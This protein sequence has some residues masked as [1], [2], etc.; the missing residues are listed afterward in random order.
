MRLLRLLAVVGAGLALSPAARAQRNWPSFDVIQQTPVPVGLV[1]FQAQD[2]VFARREPT[3]IMPVYAWQVREQFREKYGRDPVTDLEIASAIVDWVSTKLRHPFFYPDDP[4]QPRFYQNLAGDPA[5]ATMVLDPVRILDFTMAFDPDDP[6]TWPSPLCSYQN[7]AAAGLLNYFG[8]HA[9]LVDVDG[10]TS[11][12]YFSF[13]EHRWIWMDAT[14]NEHFITV[15]PGGAEVP[16]GVKELH[17]LAIAGQSSTALPVKHGYPSARW[18]DYTY[19][20]ARPDG[21]LRYAPTTYMRN[22]DGGGAALRRYHTVAYVPPLPPGLDPLP[23]DGGWLYWPRVFDGALL[24]YP[25]DGIALDASPTWDPVSYIMVVR[26]YLPF[27]TAFELFDASSQ[28]WVTRQ[29]IAVPT[30]DSTT[31]EP[32]R[33][34]WGSGLVRARARDGRGNVTQE[35][36]VQFY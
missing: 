17:A 12:E 25:V 5:Y 23:E 4:Y 30:S 9:R 20:G 3:A 27:T 2:L 1:P 15:Q 34:W 14:F 10:H 35:L 6:V 26:S 21:F 29:S 31:S 18:P 7:A 19:L 22:Y 11:L 32:I 33:V 8:L 16:L 28:T 36:I 24:D 13:S